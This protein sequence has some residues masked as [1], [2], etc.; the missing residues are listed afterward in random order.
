MGI[1]CEY[2]RLSP[3]DLERSLSDPSWAQEHIDELGDV[4]AEG[5]PLPPEKAFF[6]SIEKSW[7]KLRY[8]CA[9][10][11]GM[12]VDVVHGGAELPLEDAMDYGSARYL[13][14]EDVTRAAGFL[15]ATPF[16]EL[17]RHYDWA[18]MRG[19][20]IYLLPESE[21]EIPAD[22]DT[23]RQRYEELAQFLSAAAAAGDA[24]V[25]MLA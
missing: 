14:P 20:E 1:H 8:L 6:F 24:I 23:L 18:A 22:L 11:G 3:A 13:S 21:A 4:W 15:A 7:H 9:G 10:Q 12:P 2:V 17:A 5:D 16:G 19:A 25:L